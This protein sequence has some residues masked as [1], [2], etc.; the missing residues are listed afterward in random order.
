MFKVVCISKFCARMKSQ[1]LRISP[2][3]FINLFATLLICFFTT[4]VILNQPLGGEVIYRDED[5]V[6]EGLENLEHTHSDDKMCQVH[7][8]DCIQKVTTTEP[9]K[10]WIFSKYEKTSNIVVE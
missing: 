6:T 8:R 1:L 9:P 7:N 4:K 10:S 3:R 2:R 5:I